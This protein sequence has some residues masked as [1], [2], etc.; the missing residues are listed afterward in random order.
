MY[1]MHKLDHKFTELMRIWPLKWVEIS[2][3]ISNDCDIIFNIEV[4][5]LKLRLIYSQPPSSVQY[6]IQNKAGTVS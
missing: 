1:T 2:G 4:K 3:N 6:S 5:I